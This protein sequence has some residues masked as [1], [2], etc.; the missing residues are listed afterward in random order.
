MR[1]KTERAAFPFVKGRASYLTTRRFALLLLFLTLGS[2]LIAQASISVKQLEEFLLSRR[3][4]READAE[5]ANRLGSVALSEQLDDSG[6]ARICAKLK[7]GPKTAQQLGLLAIS[8]VFE[9]PPSS[10][11]PSGPPPDSS[12]QRRMIE[13]AR[14]YASASARNLP[15]FIAIRSTQAFNNAVQFTGKAHAKPEIELH[16]VGDY[17][18]EVTFGDGQEVIVSQESGSKPGAHRPIDHEGLTT[19]GEFGPILTTVLGDSLNGKIVWG[20]W[21]SAVD[22][23]RLAV[24]RYSV[25]KSASHDLIDLCCYQATL[26]DPQFSRFRDEPGYHGELYIDP[27]SG[28]ILRITLESELDE[29]APVKESKVSVRYE[30]VEIGGKTYICPVRGVAL[31]VVHDLQMERLDGA[32]LERFINVVHF[33]GYHKFGSTTRILD[34]Y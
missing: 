10:E 1:N 5:L 6:M 20:R 28:T 9:A 27:A 13:S 24:F 32:G 12:E 15:D 8:S 2:P 21:Q 11:L 22:G 3:A 33:S 23:K 16:F 18:R 14:A 29:Q 19:W 26:K 17:R 34:T 31:G 7:M 30:A 4:S 25:P